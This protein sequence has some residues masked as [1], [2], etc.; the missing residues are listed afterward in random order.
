MKNLV[1]SLLSDE[2]GT[3]TVEGGLMAGL[4]VGGLVL[5][6]AAIGVWVQRN[7][8]SAKRKHSIRPGIR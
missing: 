1:K 4:I 6:V 7:P 3:E 2:R 5:T 8:L